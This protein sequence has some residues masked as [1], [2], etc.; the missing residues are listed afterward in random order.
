M[1]TLVRA[2]RFSRGLL[3]ALSLVAAFSPDAGLRA[4]SPPAEPD[5]PVTLPNGVLA[6]H[7][8]VKAPY[9]HGNTRLSVGVPWA[10]F[11]LRPDGVT[12]FKP[13][14]PGFETRKGLLG[15]R[16]DWQLEPPSALQVE[17]RRLDATAPPLIVELDG[18]DDL[19][20][21][22]SI[23][24]FP[25]PGCWEVTARTNLARVTFV[26]K[27]VRNGQP[28]AGVEG[29]VVDDRSRPVADVRV[30]SPSGGYARSDAEGHFALE[31]GPTVHFEAE[32][33]RPTTRLPS[34]IEAESIVRLEP[35]SAA[36]WSPPRCPADNVLPSDVR[37][38][39]GDHM[40]FLVPRG[41]YLHPVSDVDYR[42]NEV[43]VGNE[44]LRHGWGGMWSTGDRTDARFFSDVTDMR[45]RQMFDLPH[46]MVFGAEYRGT[47]SDGTFVRFAGVLNETIEYDHITAATAATF[48][49]IIDSLCWFKVP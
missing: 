33:F 9:S 6:G 1:I 41:L 4:T 27:V 35:D 23:L 38:M 29:T 44:C 5:C 43:C 7:D 37:P 2:C 11:G 45:E 3:T 47:R 12:T 10:G 24:L 22:R 16:F 34:D 8:N 36:V 46:Q 19:F 14:G 40:R 26:T 28:P 39:Y 15:M 42:L 17:G 13:G 32:G 48:D 20:L 49:R 30:S 18:T 21:R 31:R 25:S